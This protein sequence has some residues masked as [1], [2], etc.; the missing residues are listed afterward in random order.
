[1]IWG[2]WPSRSS[3]FLLCPC[4]ADGPRGGRGRS[5]GCLFVGCSS[6]SCSPF[7]SIRFGFEFWLEVVSDSPQQ[8]ADGPRVPGG[9]SACS[10]RTVHVLPAD[11]PRAPRG[12]SVFQGSLL[13]VLLDLTNSPRPR[14]DGPPYLR[15]QSAVHWRT[16]RVARADNPPLLAGQSARACV[17]CFLVRFL[18]SFLVLPRVLQGIVSRTRCWSITSLSWRLVCDPIHRSCVTGIWLGYRPGSLRRIF[19]GSYSLPPL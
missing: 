19:T 9:Q 13:V 6:C 16:V 11:G 15:G 14:P 4:G 12:R 1:M 7:V 5:A 17:L 18:S 2:S 8:R 10:R 3:I